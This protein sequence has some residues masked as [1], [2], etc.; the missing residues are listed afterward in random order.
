MKLPDLKQKLSKLTK[1]QK[2]LAAAVCLVILL[3]ITAGIVLVAT[4]HKSA[5]HLACIG[6]EES[7]SLYSLDSAATKGTIKESGYASF[8]FTS[9][10]KE[11]FSSIYKERGSV[12][13]AVCLQVMPYKK[14]LALLQG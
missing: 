5:V 1:T 11:L 13:L 9:K 14:Q 4:K 6:S 8:K 3:D 7:V 10:Q 2:I 12:A